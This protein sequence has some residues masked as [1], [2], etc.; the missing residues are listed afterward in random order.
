MCIKYQSRQ[1]HTKLASYKILQVQPSPKPFMNSIDSTI[2]DSAS[3]YSYQQTVIGMG[4]NEYMNQ[5]FFLISDMKLKFFQ[6]SSQFL[7][8]IFVHHIAR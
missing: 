7:K 2:Q 8:S 4:L 6:Y 1:T 5:T 3:K